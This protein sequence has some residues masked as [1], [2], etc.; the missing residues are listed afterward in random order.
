MT[1]KCGLLHGTS[2]RHS[3]P[4]PRPPRRTSAV[5]SSLFSLLGK[6]AN[7]ASTSVSSGSVNVSGA[8][9]IGA[10]SLLYTGDDT[11]GGADPVPIGDG[12]SG[13]TDGGLDPKVPF[14]FKRSC[15]SSSIS[16]QLSALQIVAPECY[17]ATILFLCLGFFGPCE[18]VQ[19]NASCASLILH[20]PQ[21]LIAT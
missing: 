11:S 13:G 20:R 17:S 7:P 6:L 5:M 8:P 21:T 9:R 2:A 14:A 19:V 10:R 15:P 12:G 18:T 1:A 16:D 4:Q 3:K